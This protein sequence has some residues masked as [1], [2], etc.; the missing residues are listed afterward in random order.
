MRVLASGLT[1]LAAKCEKVSGELAAATKPPVTARAAGW[2][3]SAGMAHLAAAAAG[4]DL[5]GIGERISARGADYATA[6]AAYTQTEDES[7][8]RLHALAV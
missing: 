8:V 3:S 5:A 1:Q 4:K 2:P 6:G 7:A